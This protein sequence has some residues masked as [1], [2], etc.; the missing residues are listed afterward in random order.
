M[1]NK[2]TIKNS[3]IIAGLITV[4]SIGAVVM[5]TL[6]EEDNSSQPIVNDVGNDLETKKGV[7]TEI[8]ADQIDGKLTQKSKEKLKRLKDIGDLKSSEELDKS[9]REHLEQKIYEGF[10]LKTLANESILPLNGTYVFAS[11]I[12][13]AGK[14][15]KL[16][17][18]IGSE[19]VTE[20]MFNSVSSLGGSKVE[21]KEGM[22][23]LALI[24]YNKGKAESI[25]FTK[26]DNSL[27]EVQHSIM[28]LNF[29]NKESFENEEEQEEI[30]KTSYENLTSDEW[31]GMALLASR[32]VLDNDM[33][34]IF[35]A[36][37]EPISQE[38]G[39]L[40]GT[41]YYLIAGL[42][43]EQS[44]SSMTIKNQEGKE[45]RL[46]FGDI[47]AATH[48]GKPVWLHVVTEDGKVKSTITQSFPGANL[49]TM[50]EGVNKYIESTVL[51]AIN[52]DNK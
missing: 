39:D 24:N 22:V 44:S 16:D 7:V 30:N 37:K 20:E 29:V 36:P 52:E 33:A 23:G 41:Y 5:Q 18:Q 19:T 49:V 14:D 17:F 25:S 10:V 51:E 28:R 50:I 35:V 9:V 6:E 13:E 38:K 8:P 42:L 12:K 26:L 27:E 46:D 11:E 40:E 31:K 15:V 32:D 34:P 1:N 4:V 45:I 21:P 3:M 48:V 47:N 43:T 2:N